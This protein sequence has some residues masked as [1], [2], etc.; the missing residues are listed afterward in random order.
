[1]KAARTGPAGFLLVLLAILPL[2]PT[3]ASILRSPW[4]ESSADDDLAIL[5]LRTINAGRGEHLVGPYSRFGWSHPGP[6]EF[7][8]LLPAYRL[9]GGR[10]A[11][12]GL[13]A[14]LLNLAS[15]AALGF[16]AVRLLG[17][18]RGAP[19][20]AL[21]AGLISFLGPSVSGSAWNPHVTVLPFT[22]FLFL[23]V[24]FALEGASWL[25]AAAFVASA[26]VQT[27]L[28]YV[29]VVAA[30][31]AAA[32]WERSRTATLRAEW[33]RSRRAVLLALA[34][35]VV[36]WLPPLVEQIRETPGNLTLIARFLRTSGSAH[37]FT[38]VIGAVAPPLAAAPVRL[39]TL[40]VPST[41]DQRS[42]GAG[43]LTLLLV[44][45]LPLARAAAGRRGD[46]VARV[47]STVGLVSLAAA[48]WSVLKI[49]GEIFDY[50]V[51]W[52]AAVGVVGWSALAAVALGPAAEGPPGGAGDALA[53][54]TGLVAVAAALLLA[55]LAT[56]SNARRVKDEAPVA[57]SPIAPL[58]D[59]SEKI[60]ASLAE[61][62]V[63][64][65]LFSIGTHDTWVPAAGVFLNLHKAG[66]PFAVEEAWW[67]MFGRA[68]RPTG[69]EDVRV[70][71]GD[72]SLDGAL[73]PRPDHR[74]VAR[75]GDTTVYVVT[76][77][78]WLGRHLRR[79][80]GR[81]VAAAGTRGDPS[82]TVDGV[83]PA[84]GAVWD[85]EGSLVLESKDSFLTV[86]VP[87]GPVAG[88]VVSADN[89]DTYEVAVSGDG[90]TF[91]VA[92]TIPA[93][94][95]KGMRERFLFSTK[96][97]GAREL[98]IRPLTGDGSFSVGEISFVLAD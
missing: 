6:A 91:E 73:G 1:V 87:E 19:V 90:R 74:F 32:L 5:E 59:L 95:E 39:A 51:L 25:P 3:L 69:R 43:F 88:V 21:L 18:R 27:H 70:V 64:R 97:R 8:L 71:L 54:R 86:A 92:G 26:V 63:R 89:N 94:S 41:S 57:G 7:Y 52:T 28:G 2:L 38:E 67:P 16:V 37:A 49:R 98:R 93:R 96:L 36:L 61:S 23:A 76:D 4:P 79:G 82:V 68:F 33:P 31:S 85:A 14:A 15:A 66:I 35:L 53:R 17:V 22:L 29:P 75:S 62:R 77:P 72:L 10:T 81:V 46:A 40:L 47:L 9:L 24:A 80:P 13:G 58:L 48:L 78:E 56:A 30:V 65:P 50:L 12:L 84:E 60:R 83:V 11:A 44:A 55:A 42:I 20:V 34:L 45:L